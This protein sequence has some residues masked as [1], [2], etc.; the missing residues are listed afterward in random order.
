MEALGKKGV[1]VP[2]MLALCQDASILGTPFYLM[3]YVAGRI[4]KSPSLP[5][6]TPTQ[7][8]QV[9]T[10][11]NNTIAKIHSVDIEEAGIAEYGKHA[12][13]VKRQV[14]TWSRQYEASKT[15]EIEAMDKVIEW[16]PRNIPEQTKTSVVHGDYRVDNLIYHKDDPSQ[17]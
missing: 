17:A 9:Y 12:D 16:L 5:G 2:P 14:K 6:L 1:P 7:R 13:Y 11:M 10:A 15:G 3:S 4:Y 8:G